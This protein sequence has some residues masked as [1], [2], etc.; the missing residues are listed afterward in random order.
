MNSTAVEQIA[1]DAAD[2]SCETALL[3]LTRVDAAWWPQAQA[4]IG[5]TVAGAGTVQLAVRN[6]A[7]KNA[8]Q[9]TQAEHV[10]LRA[11]TVCVRG[12]SARSL[13]LSS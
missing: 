8:L 6:L 7:T 5:A 10:T 13:P 1:N 4:A 2:A 11:S 3:A 9:L 12:A